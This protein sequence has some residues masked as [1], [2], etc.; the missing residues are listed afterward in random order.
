MLSAAHRETCVGPA[1]A[2]VPRA[3]LAGELARRVCECHA[4]PKRQ[5]GE[6]ARP[7]NKNPLNKNPL[8]KNPLNGNAQRRAGVVLLEVIFALS[9]F[10][11]AAA[12]ISSSFSACA[13]SAGRLRLQA[14]AD[15]LAVTLLSEMQLGLVEPVDD[16]PYDFEDPYEDWSWEIVT[17]S[18]ND[19]IDIDGPVMMRVEIVI[20]HSGGE[21]VRRLTTLVPD[22]LDEGEQPEDGQPE[23]RPL[24]DGSEAP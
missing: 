3:R 19:V 7:L 8:N 24:D 17:S 2:C 9:L 1:R 21:C 4:R 14:V 6:Q 18:M 20:R 12:V 23:D 13:S 16:G 11:A 15:D 5:H 10:A 22:T